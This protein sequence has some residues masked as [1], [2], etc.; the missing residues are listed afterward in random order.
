MRRSFM[1]DKEQKLSVMQ[2]VLIS[3]G[4][5]YPP[6]EEIEDD[7]DGIILPGKTPKVLHFPRDTRTQIAVV[8]PTSLNATQVPADFLKSG[9]AVL[10]N[11]HGLEKKV[12]DNARFFLSGIT[13]AID[14]QLQK[15]T[16]TIYMFT[17]HDVGLINPGEIDSPDEPSEIE[18]T[19]RNRMFGS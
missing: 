4:V 16:D 1:Q 6:E 2:R 17:P 15:V 10:V 12:A 19:V 7:E 14:G 18:Y 8:T 11:F 3:L 5:M 13:Y 9:R